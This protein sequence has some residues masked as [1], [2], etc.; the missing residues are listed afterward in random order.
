MAEDGGYQEFLVLFAHHNMYFNMRF[1]ELESLAA[2]F[3]DVTREQL[4]VEAPPSALD[5]SPM[6]LVR[7]RQEDMRKIC[8]RS[9]L[10]KAV[11][12]V[13]ALGANC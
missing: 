7:L 3:T 9:V 8:E 11:L 4:Y 12:E 2:M 5:P 10:V 13:W 6:V 1:L